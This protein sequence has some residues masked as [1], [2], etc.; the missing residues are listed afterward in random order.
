MKIP[1]LAYGRTIYEAVLICDIVPKIYGDL[2]I[3]KK[4]E[5]ILDF[6]NG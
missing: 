2:F 4:S 6:Y 1:T 3:A 5:Y